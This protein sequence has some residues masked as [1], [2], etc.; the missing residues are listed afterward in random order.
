[1]K[2]YPLEGCSSTVKALLPR[3]EKNNIYVV[4]DINDSDIVIGYDLKQVASIKDKKKIYWVNEP[5]Y[6]NISNDVIEIDGE[7]VH[8]MN[9]FTNNVFVDIFNYLWVTKGKRIDYIDSDTYRCRKSVNKDKICHIISS[10]HN[11]APFII[12]NKDL[13]L[14]KIR[15]EV[16]IFGNQL[17]VVDIYGQNWPEGIGVLDIDSRVSRGWNDWESAK[18]KVSQSYL[19]SICIENTNVKNYVTEKF[20]HTIMSQNI[21]IY[22]IGDTNIYSWF[23]KSLIIGVDNFDSYQDLFN[24]ISSMSEKE[25]LNRVNSLIEQA[26]SYIADGKVINLNREKIIYNIYEKILLIQQQEYLL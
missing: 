2:I 9:C 5:R 24:F 12:N 25:Y 3:L 6:S 19:F 4:D 17:G 26:N 15:D 7:K 14:Y 21:P 23:D 18:L 11:Y 20:W 8:I 22:Y 13:N 1:M 10:I 16:S